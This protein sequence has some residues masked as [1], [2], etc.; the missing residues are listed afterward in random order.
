[1]SKAKAS[2]KLQEAKP[3]KT[4]GERKVRHQSR[5]EKLQARPL[6]REGRLLT[7]TGSGWTGSIRY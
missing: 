3:R 7:T 1:M 4:N 6:V 5:I 2:S